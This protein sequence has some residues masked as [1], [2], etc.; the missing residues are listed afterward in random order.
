MEEEVIIGKYQHTPDNRSKMLQANQVSS[1][2]SITYVTTTMRNM[3]IY[4]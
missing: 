1:Y 2:M 3:K 4:R